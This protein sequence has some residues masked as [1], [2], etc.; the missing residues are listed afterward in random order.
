[1]LAFIDMIKIEF[2]SNANSDIA[3]SQKQ[4]MKNNFEFHGITAPQRKV[5]QN[6]FFTK[7]MLPKKTDVKAIILNLWERPQ[8]EYQYFAQELMQK[9]IKEFEIQDIELFE[10]MIVNKSWWDTVDKISIKLVGEYFRI[11]PEQ[12]KPYV[13]KWIDSNNIWLQRTA[14]LFQL[15][16]KKKMDTSLLQYIINSLLNS[17]EFFINKAIGWVLR[18]YGKTNATWVIQYV[19]KTKLS[20]L[21]NREALRILVKT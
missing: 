19:Q 18:E 5:I 3:L 11:Y 16:Y 10:F 8:R 7:N 17:N 2:K 9:Y 15:K 1:M 4:Y 21:S 13:D 14:I 12:R 6:I 20:K